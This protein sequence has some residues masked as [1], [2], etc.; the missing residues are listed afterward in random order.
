MRVPKKVVDESNRIKRMQDRC[1]IS[2][3]NAKV[4]GG[5]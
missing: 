4:S 5:G 1:I 2:I 3:A